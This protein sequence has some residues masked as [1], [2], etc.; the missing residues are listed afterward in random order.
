VCLNMCVSNLYVLLCFLGIFIVVAAIVSFFV[1][2][3]LF[4]FI[5]Y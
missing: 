3:V 4:W 2:F 1:C 5:C